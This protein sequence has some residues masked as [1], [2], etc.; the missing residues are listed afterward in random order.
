MSSS[1]IQALDMEYVHSGATLPNNISEIV[2]SEGSVVLPIDKNH[3]KLDDNPYK[4]FAGGNM[5][6]A[7]NQKNSQN[8][9]PPINQ[10]KNVPVMHEGSTAHIM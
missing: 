8:R 6:L 2:P 9:L 7:E 4:I 1:N 3:P 5:Q 10:K